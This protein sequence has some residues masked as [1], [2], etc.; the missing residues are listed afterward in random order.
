[1]EELLGEPAER[2]LSAYLRAFQ[3]RPARCEP[4][5]C[6]ARFSRG[7]GEWALA[8]LFAHAACGIP[9]PED[10]L[11]VDATAYGWWRRDECAVASFYT[12]RKDEAARLWRELLASPELPAAERARIER[13]LAFM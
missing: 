3:A 13:N 7:R 10:R 12:G 11:F 2:V 9:M 4:L 1:M 8:H 5:V 6:L